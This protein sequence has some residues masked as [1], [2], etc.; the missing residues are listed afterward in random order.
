MRALVA[1][2]LS[3]AAGLAQAAEV[4]FTQGLGETIEPGLISCEIRGARISA[5]GRIVSD[6]GKEW[7]V[8]AETNFKTEMKATDLYNECSGVRLRSLSEL[9][10]A[11]VPIVNAG[12]SE[13]FSAYIF[14]DNYF[15]LYINGLLVGVDT[16]P[17]TPFN[18]SVVRF[19]A[20]RPF[21]V[22]VL[23]VDWEENLGLGS[24]RSRGRA[25]H[26]GDAG[27]VMVIQDAD[28][29]TVAVTDSRWKAQ[30]FYTS[31][32]PDRQCLVSDGT[33]RDSSACSIADAIGGSQFYGAHWAIPEGWQG[34]TFD[35]SDWPDAVTFTNEIVGVD[36]KPAYTNFVDVFDVE[37]GPDA[38]FIWSAN[39]VLDNLVLMRTTVE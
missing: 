29:A 3:T 27:F 2:I 32:L 24:E 28:D 8:P 25:Y 11:D 9:D 4:S 26:P 5:V 15:E 38:Q 33:I 22:A 17:F 20:D 37:E 23:G 10:L 36:N 12:G 35:D 7:I 13:V 21:S 16:V 18:S 34:V 6:D 19:A 30:T 39:L 14:A 1:L 31:P